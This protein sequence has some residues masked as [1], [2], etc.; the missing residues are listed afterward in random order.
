MK[1]FLHLMSNSR[2]S[3]QNLLL[4]PSPGHR[5]QCHHNR[6]RLSH[7]PSLPPCNS[8]DSQKAHASKNEEKS[9][10]LHAAAQIGMQ[11]TTIS[12]TIIP[13]YC[14][15]S[16]AYWGQRT[17][18]YHNQWRAEMGQASKNW[19][20]WRHNVDSLLFPATQ[21]FIYTWQWSPTIGPK[22]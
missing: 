18:K 6:I 15:L 14:L 4:L 8:N 22:L 17:L 5:M 10:T 21:I 9:Q 1:N 16:C 12:V 7:D 3:P 19:R 11:L 13:S 20:F 2:T